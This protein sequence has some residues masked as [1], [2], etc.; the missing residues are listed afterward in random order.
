MTNEALARASQLDKANMNDNVSHSPTHLTWFR[1][2]ILLC[3]YL[4]SPF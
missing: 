4:S 2:V 3:D 1:F